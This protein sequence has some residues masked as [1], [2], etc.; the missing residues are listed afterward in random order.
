MSK[1]DTPGELRDVDVRAV[2]LVGKAANKQKFA[3]FKSADYEEK[4]DGVALEGVEEGR[5]KKFFDVVK[6]FFKGEDVD[7]EKGALRDEIARRE[8]ERAL[9]DAFWA[10]NNVFNQAYHED[11]QFDLK[12]V[13]SALDEFAAIC[14]DYVSPDGTTAK[15]VCQKSGRK[16]S[17]AR[18]KKLKDAYASLAEIIAEADGEGNENM[19]ESDMTKEEIQE[20]LKGALAP[21]EERVAVIEKEKGAAREPAKAENAEEGKAE[22][23]EIVKEAVAP[24]VKR[25]ETIEKARGVSNKIPEDGMVEKDADDANFWGGSLLGGGE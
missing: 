7:A 5:A 8:K 21:I 19:G 18:L 12:A 9:R 13:L 25:I 2:S 22:L 3:I 23:A 17:G 14:A 6:A 16:V 24:L 11:G 20:A 10:L 1:P 15:G 4:E